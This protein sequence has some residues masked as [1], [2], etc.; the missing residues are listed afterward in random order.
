M[1]EIFDFASLCVVYTFWY[2]AC[3]FYGVRGLVADIGEQGLWVKDRLFVQVAI[4]TRIDHS[5]LAC[6]RSAAEHPSLYF[7]DK[8]HGYGV[9]DM[10]GTKTVDD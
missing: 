3:C 7:Q 9:I 5:F 4:T 1:S 8:G 6:L 2:R 10:I